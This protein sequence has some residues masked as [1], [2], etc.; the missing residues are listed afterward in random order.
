[1]TVLLVLFWVSL[2]ALAWTHV[3]YPAFAAALARVAPRRVQKAD[4]EPTVTVVVAAYNEES[5]I[6]RRI[7]NLLELDYPADKLQIVVS[8]DASSDRTEEIALAVPRRAGDLESARR[9]GRRAGPRGAADRRRD[10]RVLRR[11]LHL[12][13]RCAAHA[14]ARLRR[15]RRRVRLRAA[16]HPRRRGR[17]QGGRLLEL[18]D[19]AA[20]RRVA[21]RLRHRRQRLDL[22]RAPR[23][24][25]RGRPALRP[26][27][28]ASRT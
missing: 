9:Q 19:E 14:R 3:L 20:C 21:A 18:R 2:V 26:R 1:M 5:V 8:S 16:A 4:I 24:L 10:R 27:S 22:R 11:E 15:S 7:E 28:L 25:R 17:Q 13:A 23:R 12:V 6:A